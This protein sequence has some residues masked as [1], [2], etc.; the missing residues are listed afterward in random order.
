MAEGC[1]M[2]DDI[3]T[4][5]MH[6]HEVT[7]CRVGMGHQMVIGSR[8]LSPVHAE[9]VR[10]AWLHRC[11]RAELNM[12]VVKGLMGE[13]TSNE[14]PHRQNQHR[15]NTCEKAWTATACQIALSYLK[16]NMSTKLWV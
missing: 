13:P 10:V 8:L 1:G 16:D 14:N 4:A 3:M 9:C 2:H 6:Q 5:Y 7:R 11:L 12:Q 15:S